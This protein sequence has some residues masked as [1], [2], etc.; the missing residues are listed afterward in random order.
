MTTTTTIQ[1]QQ[2]TRTPKSDES[3]ALQSS[4]ST[5]SLQQIASALHQLTQQFDHHY[6]RLLFENEKS[7]LQIELLS[8]Q[9]EN[10]K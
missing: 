10:D 9:L 4:L 3:D 2:T 5:E 1:C 7:F 8:N 6:D